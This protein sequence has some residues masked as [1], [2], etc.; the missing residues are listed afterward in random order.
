MQLRTVVPSYSTHQVCPIVHPVAVV[1]SSNCAPSLQLY[2]A[3]SY[4][5]TCALT[6]IA[7]MPPVMKVTLAHSFVPS[8]KLVHHVA[9]V[10]PFAVLHHAAVVH[11]VVVV[12]HVALVHHVAFVHH[13]V[14]VHPHQLP[15]PGS[16]PPKL[17]A[18]AFSPQFLTALPSLKQKQVPL[19][20][21]PVHLLLSMETKGRA[22]KRL[23]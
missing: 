21:E 23:F 20:A 18:C 19:L 7:L 13:V 1:R 8:C 10:H 3:P 9:V 2:T 17:F 22:K 5:R 4:R 14:V 12:H 11:H 16:C 6:T 15:L